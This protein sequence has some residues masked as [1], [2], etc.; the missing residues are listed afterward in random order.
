MIMCGRKLNLFLVVLFLVSVVYCYSLSPEEEALLPTLTQEQLIEIIL[1][2]DK[3]LTALEK[4]ITEQ[5]SEYERKEQLLDWKENRLNGRDSEITEREAL[6]TIQEIM[7][8]ESYEMHKKTIRQNTI[9][10]PIIMAET[11]VIFIE[12]IMIARSF[13]YK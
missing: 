5:E 7:Y 3:G 4:I 8:Q 13:K 2:Y 12:T 10:K 9:M 11:L 6:L 1:E